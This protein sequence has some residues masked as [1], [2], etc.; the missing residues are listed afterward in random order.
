MGRI[1]FGVAAL[2]LLASTAFAKD[3][4]VHGYSQQDGTYVQPHYRTAPDSTA[5]NNYSTYPNVNPHTGD[6]GTMRNTQPQPLY[7]PP[8]PSSSPWGKSRWQ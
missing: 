4:Y 7:T 5:R 8:S 1:L 3:V 6:V 2:V